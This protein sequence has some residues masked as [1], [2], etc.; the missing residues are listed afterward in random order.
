VD[1]L[2]E[3]ELEEVDEGEL[4]EVAEEVEEVDEVAEDDLAETGDDVEELEDVEAVD[5]DDIEEELL[6]EAGGGDQGT[7]Q[8]KGDDEE[9]SIDGNVGFA[10]DDGEGSA[11][12][13]GPGNGE[14]LD[15]TGDFNEI[16]LL[17]RAEAEGGLLE[18]KGLGWD[19]EG[20]IENDERAR[21]LAEQFNQSLAAMDRFFNQYLLIPKGKY[22]V[23]NG[24]PPGKERPKAWLEMAPFYLGKFPVTNALFEIF[25]E[26]TGYKTT[27]ERLGYG[28]V[29]YPRARKR[30]DEETGLETLDWRSDLTSKTVEGACWSDLTS[31]TVEGAC[32]Y[33][34][35]GPGSTLHGKRSHPVVQVSLED[36]MAFAAWTGK[37]L[38]TEEE[39]EAATRTAQG[40]PFPWGKEWKEGACNVEESLVGRSVPGLG[41]RVRNRGRSGECFGMDLFPMGAGG[42]RKTILYCKGR[43]LDFKSAS[44]PVE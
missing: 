6:V 33:Q 9:I 11:K 32:W 23:G 44:V 19:D 4:D 13:G 10:Q 25:V 18:E 29:Y 3:D 26:K 28:T 37:R 35:L 5:G 41:E 22:P 34:P 1:E 2:A 7:L 14:P 8:G 39:W 36:A 30:I 12:G 40:Y 42:G 27:A 24:G 17:E 38:P 43:E 15:D 31:K 20:G 21:L 16:E